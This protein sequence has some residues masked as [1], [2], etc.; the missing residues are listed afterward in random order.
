[1]EVKI[2]KAKVGDGEMLADVFYRTWLATYPNEKYGITV[3]DIE[4][5][6]AKRRAEMAKVK[7]EDKDEKLKNPPPGSTTLVAWVENKIVGVCRIV[8][9]DERN[10]LKAIYVLPEYQGKG[11]GKMFWQECEKYFNLEKDTYVEVAV[12][13][14]NARAFYEKIGFVD[15][16]RRMTDEGTRMKSGV[17]IPE[18]EMLL[19]AK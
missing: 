13:N 18:M 2:E 17:M 14:D 11:I 10:Q 19:K 5:R 8:V 4:D 7:E 12:Y 16:G 15:T 1:M 9:N 3:D 6:F